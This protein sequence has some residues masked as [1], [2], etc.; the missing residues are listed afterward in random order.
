MT[1]EELLLHYGVKGMKWGVRKP[2]RTVAKEYR[3]QK[4]S[5]KRQARLA[6]STASI[7]KLS[8]K[9]LDR[10]LKRIRTENSIQQ[11]AKDRKTSIPIRLKARELYRNKENMK[12]EDLQKRLARIK[13]EQALYSEI[14]KSTKTSRKVIESILAMAI[15]PTL[16]KGG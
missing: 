14:V 7:T 12:V 4:S 8:N 1:Q 16:K 10:K 13:K 11:I 5:L 6:K 3:Y 2:R 9:Q 15:K